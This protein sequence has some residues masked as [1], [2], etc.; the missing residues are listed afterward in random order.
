MIARGL[1]TA[2]LSLLAPSAAG[3]DPSTALRAS[4]STVLRA[5]PSTALRAGTWVDP[6]VAAARD[7]YSPVGAADPRVGPADQAAPNNGVAAL[8]RRFEQAIQSGDGAAYFTL[9]TDSADRTRARD[10]SSSELVPGA[11]RAVIQER[12]RQ[13]LP[14][15]LPEN[16][17]S[18]LVDA[19]VEYGQ[20]A[21]IATWT[22]DVKR[23]GDSGGDRE[24][25]IADVTPVSSVESLYRL[26]VNTA[27][28][29]AAHDLKISVEDLE[30]TLTDGSVFVV[31]VDQGV[32]GA[33][34]M[35]H[36]VMRFHPTPE[37]EQGQVKIF[38]G[39]ETLE[40][41][42]DT[43]YVRV[44]PSDFE[45]LVGTPNLE[46][47]TVDPRELRR[48]LDVFRAESPKSFV[49]DLGD[50]SRD[51]WSLLPGPGDFLAEVKTR[52]F[53]TLT[54][55]RSGGEAEDISLFDRKRHRNISI[56]ASKQRTALRGRFFNEDEQADYDILDY[57][58]EAA[59]SPDRQW[60]DGRARLRI[61][62]RAYMLGTLTLKL[63]DPL[64]VQSISSTEYGRLFGIRV[65]NQNSIVINLPVAAPRDKELTLTVVY[66][67]RLE[68]QTPDRETLELEQRGMQEDA[69]MLVAAEPS[70]LY[71]NRSFWYPQAPVSDYATASLR[72]TIPAN[73]DCV[74]SGELEPGFPIIVPGK[75]S[76]QNRKMYA[77]TATKPLRYLAVIVSRFQRAETV[78][79]AFPEGT[80]N[81][82]VEANP[83]QTNRGRDLAAR[84]A[85][86]AT[87]Y[88]SLLGDAPY[89]SFTIALIEN[90]LPGGH[91]PG[92]FAALNQPLPTST[93]SWRNDPVAF[94]AFPEFFLAHEL[95]HQ[96]WGQA[97]GWRNYHEQWISEGFAQYF[98]ALYAQHQR[99]DETFADVMRQA[100][101]TA[102]D[103]TDQGPI[104]LG[105][106]LGHIRGQSRVFR[107]LVY[108]KS[109][110]VLH[111]LRALI[112]DDAFF[113]GLRQFYRTM[114]FRKAGTEDVRASMEA[115]SGRSLGR[116]FERW[117]FGSTLPRLKFSYTVD[118]SEVVLRVDQLGEE[119]F[120]LPLVVSLQYA[121]R[122]V[123]V[124]IPVVDRVVEKRVP[125]TGTLR[126]VDVNK[127][128]GTLADVTKS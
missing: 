39:S 79:V 19:F 22:V 62:V 103:V 64:V 51:S 119:L 97:I 82:A 102:M 38:C 33:V 121:D 72:I 68:P 118:G 14:G 111:M 2:M 31:N 17:Y 90:D 63:A 6:Y 70:V 89:P 92:Y 85:S 49:L 37:T 80:L 25:A 34:L 123:D 10:F 67:G 4:P 23:V 94:G 44:H 7:A 35:G 71:S 108:N 91:S 48:A 107:A 78:T 45:S 11:T 84:A 87:F 113:R 105:Y 47:K 53:D 43:V 98:A 110:A 26:S 61:K 74:A 86:I 83:R 20:R 96:W 126:G 27:K 5:S 95:A 16:G 3:A 41:K 29:Y 40:S 54:Y 69:S 59:F 15:T 18:L 77:F 122:K 13:P 8:L 32:T 114:R 120:D 116:F 115:A 42:F 128:E 57:Q 58:I 117:I 65:K 88:E 66:A 104:Y 76:S 101:R 106:R 100:R 56:Y 127:D 109:A 73:L 93:L 36:G 24:W 125:L 21:R 55:A 46:A 81:L 9:L 1:I 60:I 75:D 12:D 124:V 99:G 28:Q 50:L 52:R 30:L 112:G